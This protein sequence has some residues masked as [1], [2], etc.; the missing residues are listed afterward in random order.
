MRVNVGMTCLIVITMLI[1]MYYLREFD[2]GLTQNRSSLNPLTHSLIDPIGNPNN[3]SDTHLPEICST[4]VAKYL[5]PAAHRRSV[6][7]LLMAIDS[8][9]E[10]AEA[11]YILNG[12]TL[13]GQQRQLPPGPM[14]W[15]DDVDVQVVA[16]SPELMVEAKIRVFRELNNATTSPFN[17]CNLHNDTVW[18]GLQCSLKVDPGGLPH[19]QSRL[20]I[21]FSTYRSFEDFKDSGRVPYLT[22]YKTPDPPSRWA[23]RED[24]YK[25][26]MHPEWV[27]PLQRCPYM[28]FETWCPARPMQI[29]IQNYGESVM[30]TLHTKGHHGNE[31]DAVTLDM[32]LFPVLFKSGTTDD[33]YEYC[34]L[35]SPQSDEV[36]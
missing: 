36:S 29:M 32:R 33:S 16:R 20:D 30:Y 7:G 1:M 35:T 12:G 15:D 26:S 2:R 4:P 10:R 27:F 28:D 6:R 11:Q 22:V 13:I 17:E 25:V 9:M 18:E 19:G 34:N 8:V 21:F 3:Q 31:G 24:I 23:S 14:P 5:L